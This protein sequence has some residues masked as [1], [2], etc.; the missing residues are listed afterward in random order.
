MTNY[1]KLIKNIKEEKKPF[2]AL[3]VETTG[4]MNGNDNRLTQVALASYDYNKETG[5]YELQDKIFMLRKADREIL[6]NIEKSEVPSKE[7]AE[8]VLY[9][10]FKYSITKEIKSQQTQLDKAESKGDDAKAS[11]IAGK[12]QTLNEKKKYFDQ[13]PTFGEVRR[14]FSNVTYDISR[15][16]LQDAV[17]YVENKL[18][19]KIAEMKDA[20]KLDK[21][22]SVQGIRLE[23]YRKCREGLTDSEL[24]IGVTNFLNKYQ[25]DDTVFINNGT[26]FTNHYLE[27]SGIT[28]GDKDNTIDLTQAERSMHGGKSEWT[29]SIDRFAE[30]YMNDTGR[31]IRIFDAFTKALCIGEMTMSA[32]EMSL[33]NTSEK[34]LE[35]MVKE[36]AESKDSDY[37]MS[38]TRAM[39]LEWI[40]DFGDR[41]DADYHFNSLEYVDFGNDRRY[42]D[43]NK[44]FEINDNFEV[45]LE[46]EKTPIKT[47]PEL[48]AKIK[49]LNADISKELLDKI[50]DKFKETI[51]RAYEQKD[52]KKKEELFADIPEEKRKKMADMRDYLKRSKEGRLTEDEILKEKENEIMGLV[53][54]LK[55]T[56]DEKTSA[57]KTLA[58]KEPAIKQ[59]FEAKILP[60]INQIKNLLDKADIN[61]IKSSVSIEENDPGMD[62]MT[63][64]TRYEIDITINPTCHFL[65]L[66]DGS[67]NLFRYDYNSNSPRGKEEISYKVY[68][69]KDILKAIKPLKTHLYNDVAELLNQRIQNAA[70]GLDENKFKSNLLTDIDRELDDFDR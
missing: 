29:A 7:N 12:I 23:E 65:K 33:I 5:K 50:H 51:S 26:Y 2:I 52:E 34:Y 58:E 21:I 9:N 17:T 27:K 18:N 31:E 36:Q 20:D 16:F 48:E 40:P 28:I 60:I 37:V 38:K 66:N 64:K 11:L 44:M 56:Y 4:V 10:D 13:I 41:Y 53:S 70:K 24:A 59:K 8:T 62:G 39:S 42:V 43:I 22:L 32:C 19:D 54:R 46:G 61:S 6:E 57:A 14:L 69:V 67:H 45:T 3:D 15:G 49:A 68:D 35:N 63:T 1:E 55:K 25:K 47:W 30:N